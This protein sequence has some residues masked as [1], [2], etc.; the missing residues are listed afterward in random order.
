MGDTRWIKIRKSQVHFYNKTELYYKNKR[1]DYILYKPVGKAFPPVRIASERYPDLYIKKSDKAQAVL[2]AQDAF[3]QEL[4]GRIQKGEVEEV[5]GVLVNIVEETLSEPRGGT[6]K[7]AATM[8]DI[9]I[10]GYAGQ[11]DVI[12]TLAFLSSKDYTTALHSVNVM[13]LTIGFASHCD[14]SEE[15]VKIMGLSA[16]FHDVGKTGVPNEVLNAT[17]KLTNEEFRKMK[18]HSLMGHNILK[19]NGFR[20]K[21]ILRAAIEHHEKMDGSGYPRGVSSISEI[22][23]II[24]IIDC[25][26]AITNDDRPY[27]DAMAPLSALR[28]IKEEMEKGKFSKEY[29][30]KFA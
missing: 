21:D 29:F 18:A 4:P 28:I 14:Y 26:E 11:K 24:G 2:E 13:A 5:K 20:D 10:D 23:Q 17:R 8:V 30:E 22:G 6:L 27:R 16:L 12:K 19:S 3:Y 25:Y 9:L 7:G 1:G 15:S